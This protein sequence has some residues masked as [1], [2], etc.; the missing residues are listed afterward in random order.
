M[1]V[2]IRA[3]PLLVKNGEAID[4]ATFPYYSALVA[5]GL[6]QV[7]LRGTS[8]KESQGDMHKDSRLLLALF[9]VP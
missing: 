7:F 6:L 3:T 2:K 8:R 9:V 4:R 1:I 5:F